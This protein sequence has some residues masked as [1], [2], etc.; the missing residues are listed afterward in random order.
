LN[1]ELKIIISA[2]ID[3]LKKGC[4]DAKKEVEGVSSASDKG[5]GKVKAAFSAMGSAAATMAK[6]VT[7]AVGTAAAGITALVT[8]ATN[9]Y[10]DYEQLVGGVDTLF[11]ESSEKVQEYASQAYKTAG[12]SAN[13]Y[14]ET[15]TSFSASLLQS[16]GNDTKEAAEYADMA[17][18]DMA[19]NANKMG[20]SMESIQNAYQGFA[21]QNY[22]MLDNL[23]LGYGGTQ[24][25]M[26]RLI[27][28]ANRVKEANGEMAD[29]TMDSFADV[30]EAIHIVQT[31]MGITG[32]TA[33]EASATIAG[34]TASM[35][36][37]WDNLLVGI[38]DDN[39]DLETLM[40]EFVET[41]GTAADNII[42]RIQITL[43]RAADLVDA[44]VPVIVENIPPL[45]ESVVPAILESAVKL[46]EA[47][48][49]GIVE[50]FPTLLTILT[51]LLADVI[52]LLGGLIPKITGVILE[53]LPGLI[54]TILD[55]G[56]Q[57]L[58][59]LADILPKI[60]QQITDV[61]PK[62]IKAVVD[63]IPSLLNAAINLFMAIVEAI[64]QIIPPLVSALPSIIKSILDAVLNAIPQLLD[65]ALDL[66]QAIVDAIPLIIPPLVEALPEIIETLITFCIEA[67]PQLIEAAVE[68]L[69]AIIEAIPLI[70]P[71]LVEALPEIILAIIE[72]LTENIPLL[73]ETAVDLFFAIIEAIPLILGELVLAVGDIIVTI[74]KT[75]VESAPKICQAGI[76]M[77]KGLWDSITDT[78]KKLPG[79]LKEITDSIKTN[80]VEKAK[81]LLDF[82]WSLPKIKLPHFKVT[83][84]LDLFALPPQIP[85][86][87]IEWYAKGGVFD[88]PTLFGKDGGL[89]GLGEAG[90][91]AIV[92]LE[93][94]LGWLDKIATMLSDKLGGEERPIILQVDGKT[95]ARTS[96]TSINQLTAQTGKLDLVLA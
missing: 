55:I 50:A 1:E 44:L 42:P 35:K 69:M 23:K 13:Q 3:K 45:I 86:V 77:F 73:L 80:L 37:S 16:L 38:A 61:L 91:E 34:S 93:N 92:P 89:G 33:A 51:D 24:E 56:V 94:N 58:N 7:A 88:K 4:Q 6:A 82:E 17:I 78:V 63:A 47:L 26:Q 30:V 5:S 74:V 25:E 75:I 8:A 66:L 87:S 28:D 31:E 83:G 95:F 19:D 14:M 59:I 60:I 72:V 62:I 52:E 18:I 9:G 84:E 46:V 15:V 2:E 41:V 71:P 22:T 76:D 39:A 27:D 90:A 40:N 67:I 10:A 53:A 81:K 29:L 49:D 36:A 21:K 96:I 57:V 54:T 48:I 43:E 64:P 65:A 20:T 11:K 85:S 32:T 79:K 70:I 68:L 12:L